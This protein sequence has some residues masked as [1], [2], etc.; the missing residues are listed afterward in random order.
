MGPSSVGLLP[1]RNFE[2]DDSSGSSDLNERDDMTKTRTTPYLLAAAPLTA[3]GA[4]FAAMGA[5]G[6]PAFGYAS[7]GLLVPGVALL[8][9]AAWM[10]NRV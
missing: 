6:N 9:V 10:R 1:R 8:L 7:V 5:A 4:A 3:V 2:A